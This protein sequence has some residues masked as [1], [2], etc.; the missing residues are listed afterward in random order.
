MT[1]QSGKSGNRAGQFRPGRSGNPGGRPKGVIEVI[2]L[3]R[4]QTMAAIR[5]LVEVMKS[6]ESEAARVSAANAIL[7]RG[8]GK[9]P[10]S[11]TFNDERD[12]SEMTDA[13][14]DAHIRGHE[15]YWFT[16]T[17]E[18][19]IAAEFDR[20]NE[21]RERTRSKREGI[22]RVSGLA[23]KSIGRGNGAAH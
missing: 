9:A 8:W 1:F 20:L 15:E 4:K 3:A 12:P 6:G 2:E 23:A 21:L 11:L 10:Q 14:L 19:E 5:T 13:E 17:S 22:E 16:H 18:A 7:D